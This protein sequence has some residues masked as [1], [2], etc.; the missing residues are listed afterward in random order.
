MVMV[1]MADAAEGTQGREMS[2]NAPEPR[3]AHIFWDLP[4]RLHRG[5]VA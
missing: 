5:A 3:Y 2:A 4:K 1:E